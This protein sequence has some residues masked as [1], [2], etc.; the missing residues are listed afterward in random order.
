[1]K[2]KMQNAVSEMTEQ[3]L[4]KFHTEYKT[5]GGDITPHQLQRLEHLQS[6]YTSLLCRLVFQNI[7]LATIEPHLDSMDYEDLMELAN[8][9][10][11]NGSWDAD[12]EGQK[13][14]SKAELIEAI[15][16]MLQDY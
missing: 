2:T 13:P 7:D 3:I 16:S 9:L 12:E 14:I 11:W 6:Q 10:D 5:T 8:H 4:A 1:M 15:S